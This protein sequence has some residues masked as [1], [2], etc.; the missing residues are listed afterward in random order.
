MRK[1]LLSL[2]A[3]LSL[4]SS[5]AFA[6]FTPFTPGQ[7]LTA[8]ELN[9]A[10]G[11]TVTHQTGPLTPNYF[12]FGNGNGDLYAVPLT[13]LIKGNGTSAP[14]SA[15][16]GTDYVSALSGPIGSVGNNTFVTS[17]TGSG[18]IFVMN[19]SPF[20][21]TPMF[22][23]SFSLGTLGFSGSNILGSLQS[24]VNSYNQFIIQNTN[25]G[26]TASSDMVVSNNLGTD[27]TYYGDFGMNSS[28]FSGSG[29]L[30]LPNAVYLTST[31]GDLVLGTTT[32]NGIHFTVNNG[33]TD[34][35]ALSS[36][37]AWTFNG[38]M[39]LNGAITANS[40]ITA[41]GLLTSGTQTGSICIDSS[42]HLLSLASQNCFGTTSIVSPAE[43]G[44]GVNNGTY[45]ITLGGNLLTGSTL[46]TT[47]AFSTGGAF[48]TG[49]T[50]S[51]TGAFSTGGAFTTAN[52][53]T[54]SGAHPL[55]LTTSAT[56]NVTLPASGTVISSSTALSGAVTGTPSSS[57]YLRG[58]GIWAAFSPV[59]NG[60][61]NG[62]TLSNDGTSPNT[63]LD[64]AAGFAADSTNAVMI[65]GTAFTK[66][67][68]GSSCTGSSNAFVAGTG[69]CGMFG[70][71]VAASTWYHEFG[72]ICTGSYDVYF[73]TSASAANKPACASSYRYL[74]SFK[75]NGS[76]QIIAF[77]QNGQTFLWATPTTDVSAGGTTSA[78]L[79]TFNAPLGVT[80]FPYLNMT[81]GNFQGAIWSPQLGSGYSIMD[82]TSPYYV[83]LPPN[84][85]TN[86][87]SQLYI[88]NGAS[89]DMTIIT[90]GYVNP[91]V[92]ANF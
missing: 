11:A 31:S 65:T 86:T 17:Q 52:T 26:T 29:S 82:I 3:C 35:A 30:N 73:D 2:F 70:T 55:T 4:I 5:A 63:V 76:S 85:L 71:A 87:S 92:S 48:T 42:G 57:N 78:V 12:V 51:T 44:T 45:T 20:I 28:G 40:T 50:F 72:I 59:T 79:T 10:F 7:I 80:T 27:T 88:K 54:T 46:S 19:T 1:V 33:T 13:G 66:Q 18:S 24:N 21:Y 64:T 67:I 6:Q 41:T 23:G 49:S 68:S 90:L 36:A 56:T 60:Y 8:A 22:S 34:G 32:S 74:G 25:S 89:G 77:Y 43:G 15:V 84:Q 83:V 91:H 53:F 61:I 39:T 58:D 75:T 81:N 69:N 37:G 62:F 38:G 47:G 14:S 16:P 9:N